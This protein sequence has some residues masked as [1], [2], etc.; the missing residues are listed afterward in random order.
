VYLRTSP[1]NTLLVDLSSSCVVVAGAAVAAEAEMLRIGCR[2]EETPQPQPQALLAGCAQL[3]ARPAALAVGL[4]TELTLRINFVVVFT[5]ARE[6]RGWII[7]SSERR[8]Q[9]CGGKFFLFFWGGRRQ[10]NTKAR[11][12]RTRGCVGLMRLNML[13]ECAREDAIAQVCGGR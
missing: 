13:S 7:V 3:P 9:Q 5:C 6:V 8:V 12:A 10:G 1:P 2:E 4:T 11:R